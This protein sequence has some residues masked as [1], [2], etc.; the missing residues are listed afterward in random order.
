M[1]DKEEKKKLDVFGDLSGG[2]ESEDEDENNLSSQRFKINKSFA[3]EYDKRKRR[4]ELINADLNGDDDDD[5]SSSDES[6]DDNAELLTPKVDLQ[7]LKV[8]LCRSRIS[9]QRLG[10]RC[11][12]LSLFSNND[13]VSYSGR[14]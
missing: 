4:E 9:L 14:P 10:D 8:C 2:E 6:E 7:I 11:S 5:D 12:H 13:C 1:S 3:S